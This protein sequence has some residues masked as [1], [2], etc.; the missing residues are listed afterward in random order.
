MLRH[1]RLGDTLA[2]VTYSNGMVLYVNS[3]EKDAEAD[4]YRIPAMDYLAVGG[5]NE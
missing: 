5:E 2:R 4:G 1:D 3:G